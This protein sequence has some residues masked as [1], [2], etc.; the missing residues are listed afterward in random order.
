[1]APEMITNSRCT[2]KVDLFSMGILLWEICTGAGGG[3]FFLTTCLG[4]HGAASCA[5]IVCMFSK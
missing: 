1:M 4:V 3:Q 5:V 2:E